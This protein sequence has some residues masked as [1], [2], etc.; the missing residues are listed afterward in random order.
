MSTYDAYQQRKLLLLEDD[1]E[2]NIR[3]RQIFTSLLDLAQT[4][5]QRLFTDDFESLRIALD[6]IK[7]F[8]AGI[9]RADLFAQD[10]SVARYYT[11]MFSFQQYVN[12]S[13]RARQGKA[14]EEIL[15]TILREHTHCDKVPDS[16]KMGMRPILQETFGGARVPDNDI[17]VLGVHSQGRKII[18][19]QVRSRDDTGGTTAKGSLV[20]LLRGLL[21]LK[22][23]PK[24]E[25]LYLICVWDQ[26]KAQ[27]RKSTIEK[28]YSS[29]KDHTKLDRQ[30]FDRIGEGIVISKKITL[31]MAYGTTE[32]L[33]SI[34]EWNTPQS[35]EADYDVKKIIGAIQDWDDLWVAYALASLEIDVF[36]LRGISNV[37][38]LNQKFMQLGL[39]FDFSSY[40]ALQQS[41]NQATQQIVASWKEDSLPVRSPADQALYIR[42]LLF[43]KAIYHKSQK[44][45]QRK[46][47]TLRDSSA[48]YQQSS[49]V[50]L[51]PIPP[52]PSTPELVSF[53][54]LVPEIEETTYLTH[55]LY[56]YPAKFIPQ[57]VRY[58]IREYSPKD[59]WIIDPFA[60]S[61]TVGLEALLCQRNVVL[62]D[63]N[64][65][66]AHIVPLK[67]QIR[68]TDLN[69]SSL[70]ALLDTMRT[71]TTR[72]SPD[73]SNLEYWYP[74]EI[75]QSLC[76]YWGWQKRIDPGP[77]QMIVEAALLKASKQF[78]YAEHKAP[79]LFKS[80]TKLAEIT[81]L[82]QRDWQ[83]ELNDLIYTT[84]FDTLK[85][86]QQSAQ[87]LAENPCQVI[88]FGGV[89][90]ATFTLPDYPLDCLISSPPYLQ[91]Q[92]Y[93]RTSK[94]ELYWL[95]HSETEIKQL[96]KLE[97][98]Y[99]HADTIVETP[100]L[101]R[102]RQIVERTDLRALLDSYFCYTLRALESSM[103]ALR[104]HGRACIFVGNPKIDGIEV[105]TWR[106][107]E[108]YFRERGF[109]MK[110]VFEDRIK[111]RQLFGGR[112]NKNPD[113]MKSEF[114]LVLSKLS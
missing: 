60:G 36:T 99:R 61:G 64:P 43:L 56:Y 107:I 102:V 39:T 109:V 6:E 14:L 66:L 112:K 47:R 78:S 74:P 100:T 24:D 67:M 111:N 104:P 90:S 69:Q 55:A 12:S 25:I 92:E 84:A 110:Q 29:L 80:K 32:I 1:T 27:Q 8:T 82:M 31:K 38:L 20:E 89:D 48:V 85:R 101:N 17:D 5:T 11:L 75:L 91:A 87:F 33:R 98:P 94:L 16:V 95:G 18:L 70:R 50:D 44:S 9:D 81:S 13:Y 52:S 37:Q 22:K 49:L 58:C 15:K 2:Q 3:A 96:S 19:M 59:G 86:V 62:L 79:K 72:Y 4:I 97:I 10:Y 103:S 53:R 28:I 106:I 35:T 71:S 23:T 105:E 34:I 46:P 77:Y 63:L 113:G 40:Q 68:Q 45:P 93:I 57:V 26:R 114:L 7:Q 88:A 51:Q 42:D 108:E 30:A 41:I 21:R 83:T 76:Y 54:A 65:L 73:W